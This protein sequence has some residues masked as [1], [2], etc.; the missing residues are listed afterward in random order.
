[1]KTHKGLLMFVQKL[2]VVVTGRWPFS[3]TNTTP[4]LYM[5]ELYLDDCDPPPPRNQPEKSFRAAPKP[6]FAM[7][8]V[9]GWRFTCGM[10]M[11]RFGISSSIRGNRSGKLHVF[12]KF[13]YLYSWQ[14]FSRRFLFVC[15]SVARG[16]TTDFQWL[17]GSVCVRVCTCTLLYYNCVR[18]T[19]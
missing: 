10:L 13:T 8:R 4:L 6:K 2:T 7:G 19:L 14:F 1:M 15:L 18:I 3:L 12:L 9:S 16:N 11:S 5:Q 17:S